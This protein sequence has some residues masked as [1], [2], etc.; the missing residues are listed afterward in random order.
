V[1]TAA[2]QVDLNQMAFAGANLTLLGLISVAPG[3]GRF[4]GGA[5]N[6]D[7]GHHPE[8]AVA[9]QDGDVGLVDFQLVDFHDQRRRGSRVACGHRTVALR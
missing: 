4:V 8:I 1:V 2:Q 7:Y 9:V 3:A 5:H 6:L